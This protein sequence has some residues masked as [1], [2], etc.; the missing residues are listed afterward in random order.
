[1]A[2]I[3]LG[4]KTCQTVGELPQLGEQAPAFQLITKDMKTVRLDDFIGERLILNIFPS[5][6]TAICA[7]TTRHF[8]EDAA[9]L[10]NTKVITISKDLPMALGRFLA[11]EGLQNVIMTS[12]Y[13]SPEFGD[14]YG[15]TILDGGFATLLSRCVVVL[16]E[17]HRVIYTEQV[18]EIGHEPD[19]DAALEALQ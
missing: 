14:D 17:E 11:A 4:G 6:D 16:D 2:T 10:E 3:T 12:A 8:N 18:P 19:Y 13:R 1:M 9:G 15:V 7:A 5:I